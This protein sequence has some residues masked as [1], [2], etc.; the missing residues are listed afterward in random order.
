[1]GWTLVADEVQALIIAAALSRT[2][3]RVL[4]EVDDETV[5]AELRGDAAELA[6]RLDEAVEARRAE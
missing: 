1:M 4:D 2:L 6:R 3:A 5:D